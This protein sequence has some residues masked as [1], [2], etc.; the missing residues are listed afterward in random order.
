M[1]TVQFKL[2]DEDREFLAIQTKTGNRNSK[3]FERS[4]ILLALDKGKKHEEIEDFYNVSR[5]TIWR[6]KRKYKKFGVLYAIKDAAHSGQPVKYKEKE[7]AEIV[8]LACTKAPE[9]RARWTIKLLERTLKQREGMGTINRETIRLTLKK[10][11]VSL[12]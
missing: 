4:Y 1:R 3:E 2:M 10:M 6:V 12:G 7:K 8:A 5:I 11:N 9:G